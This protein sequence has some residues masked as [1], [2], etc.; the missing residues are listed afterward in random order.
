[1]ERKRNWFIMN[2]KLAL[3]QS[4]LLS[5]LNRK[6]L[7]VARQGEKAVKLGERVS[8]VEEEEDAFQ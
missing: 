2:A 1:M 8:I 7:F 6:S 4:K 3:I 5:S